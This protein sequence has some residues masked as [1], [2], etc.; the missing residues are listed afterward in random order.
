MIIAGILDAETQLISTQKFRFMKNQNRSFFVIVIAALAL[1]FAGCASSPV[2]EARLVHQLN[3]DKMK[4]EAE[5]AKRAREL[6]LAPPVQTPTVVQVPVQRV[7]VDYSGVPG[8][9]A[10]YAEPRYD[11][12]MSDPGLQVVGG[13]GYGGGYRNSPT[14]VPQQS[15]YGGGYRSAPTFVP[16]SNCVQG[17]YRSGPTFVPQGGYGGGGRSAPTFVSQQRCAPTYGGGR[18]H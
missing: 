5:E 4:F 6:G 18:R 17:G 7:V 3:M 1:L 14:F 13:V 16:Q 15:C 2:R 9:Y 10:P 8:G 12:F 11:P